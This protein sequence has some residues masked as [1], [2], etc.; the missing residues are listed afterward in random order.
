MHG[1]TMKIMTMEFGTESI[2][3]ILL[4]KMSVLT[5]GKGETAVY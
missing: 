3:L 2:P 1:V 5:N 4:T